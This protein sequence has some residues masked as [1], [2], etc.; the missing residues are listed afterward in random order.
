MNKGKVKDG[1]KREVEGCVHNE[2]R[3]I[4]RLKGSGEQPY[5]SSQWCHLKPWFNPDPCCHL[6]PYLSLWYWSIRVCYHQRPDRQL[7]GSM[8]ESWAELASLL[9]WASQE[10]WPWRHENRRSVLPIASWSTWESI[11]HLSHVLKVMLIFLYV[12]AG[13]KN[14]WRWV[15]WPIDNEG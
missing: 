6:G 11:P 14:H 5:L 4:W 12:K 15:F 2:E 10:N 3:W 9:T 13:K 8:S 7:S 1:R